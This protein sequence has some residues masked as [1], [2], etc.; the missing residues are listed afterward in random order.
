TSRHLAL[1]KPA[2][3]AAC[4][5]SGEVVRPLAIVTLTICVVFFPIVFL[6]GIGKFLFTPLAMSVIFA[7]VTSLLLATTLVPVCAAKFFR[8]A[9]HKQAAG[10]ESAFQEGLWFDAL[11]NRYQKLLVWT[12]RWRWGVLVAT[13]VLFIGSMLLFKFIGTELFPQVDA[14]QFM[15]RM[16]ATPGLRIENTEKLT[17]RVEDF[18]R[19]VIPEN[20]RKMVI[21]NIGV[22]YDWP[23]AYTPNSGSQ[24][25]FILV[26]LTQH[27]KTSVF[28]YV[29]QL[30]QKLPREFPG[31]EF[32]FDTG[33]MLSAALN[34][35]LPSPIDI[36]VEGNS[37]EVAHGIAG[38]IKRFAENVPGAVDVRIQQRLDAPQIS[39]DVDRV[40][41]AQLGLSEE[42]V[43]K[44]IVS[45]FNSS[46]NFSPS[47][48]VDEKNGNHYFIGV[49]YPESDIKSLDTLRDIPIT[50]KS[51]PVPIRLGDIAK[52]GFATAPLEINHRN[53]TRVTDVYVNVQG[54]DVG[55]VAAEIQR[56]VN[57]IQ[58]DRAVVP[59]G[60][61]IHSRGEV[62]AMH[63]S[64]SSLGF[65]FVLAVV[66][67]Y[68]V[69]VFQFRSF[70]D[71][72]IVMFAVPLGLIGVV[73]MLFFTGTTL[74]IQSLMGS[75]MMVGIV[76]SFSVLL[77]EFA[78]RLGEEAREQG[79]RKSHR[80]IVV[81]AAGIRLRPILMTGLAA[82]LGLIPMA[83]AGGANTPLARAVIGGVLA[84][85]VMV[86]FVVP[87][88]YVLLKGDQHPPATEII[89]HA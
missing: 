38:K 36:Q 72:F 76:V 20:E 1:G 35:G 14:G 77:V 81:E 39:V 87:I 57:Q 19:N 50:D 67:V 62:Q 71:P 86:L 5:G 12:L 4:D 44:N 61:F 29:K 89:P 68:L 42:T 63:E 47:F 48:W 21:A 64:F 69:M 3:E 15:I 10:G 18:V 59:E 53:I 24:D 49:Q 43:V 25:A 45:A 73:L 13:A 60:Y 70:L 41:A 75:I 65:G 66:L 34:G 26:Q 79:L 58:N 51:Q 11:R 80:E 56:Y 31:T 9:H 55:S 54:R 32:D 28:D 16:R 6:S 46:I 2:F 27:H 84:A 83:I 74:N 40:K 23:A 52:I 85:M 8:A 37:L 82:V 78:N 22:L 88:M 30:R 17:T 33:G 7:I